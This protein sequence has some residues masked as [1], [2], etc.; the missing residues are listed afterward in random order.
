MGKKF[1]GNGHPKRGGGCGGISESRPSGTAG[2]KL[3]ACVALALED[4]VRRSGGR[5][6]TRLSLMSQH[7]QSVKGL[8]GLCPNSVKGLDLTANELDDTAGL[9]GLSSLR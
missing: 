5:E 1:V 9:T 6:P 4:V 7:L 8:A 2:E 3:K